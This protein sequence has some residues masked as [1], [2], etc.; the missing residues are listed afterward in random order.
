[1]IEIYSVFGLLDPVFRFV[2][3]LLSFLP[4]FVR[5][6][7]W[8]ALAGLVTMLIYKK[9]SRQDK[10][11]Q[12]ADE[13]KAIKARLDVMDVSDKE[14]KSLIMQSLKLGMKRLKVSIG[15]A[16]I[17]AI[18]VIF[19]AI[20]IE[21][22]YAYSDPQP[23]DKA[24]IVMGNP[25]GV[26]VGKAQRLS[27]GFVF[28]WPQEGQVLTVKTNDDKSVLDIS[29][30]TRLGHAAAPGLSRTFFGAPAGHIPKE[31]G[32][33]HLQVVTTP[34]AIFKDYFVMQHQWAIVYFMA[35]MIA[36]IAIKFALKIK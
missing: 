3:S 25:E 18:P 33:D 1:M 8:G 17:S 13:V 24:A 5:L 36:S 6:C 32:V 21:G 16:L 2:D 7:L 19:L 30:D 10:I 26:E 23:G 27:N 9:L 12:M 4:D 20:Y 15:P 34:R 31:A 35:L 11:T 29:P 28:N 14:Y 22:H